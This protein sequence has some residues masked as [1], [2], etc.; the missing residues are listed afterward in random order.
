M[1]W[2]VVATGLFELGI[3]TKKRWLRN[4]AKKLHKKRRVDTMRNSALLLFQLRSVLGLLMLDKYQYVVIYRS[5]VSCR[6]QL[7]Q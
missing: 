6:N 5:K 3:H 2:E 1:E 4:V 7:S